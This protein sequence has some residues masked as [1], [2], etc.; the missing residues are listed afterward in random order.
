MAKKLDPVDVHV[1]ARLKA[2]RL[3]C[4][5]RLVDAGKKLKVSHTQVDKY[6]KGINRIAHNNLAKLAD[7][8]GHAPSY[9]Y[10]GAPGFGGK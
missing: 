2:A 9:F 10:H 7:L 4:K 6:E 8:Y 1:G 5:L 3:K